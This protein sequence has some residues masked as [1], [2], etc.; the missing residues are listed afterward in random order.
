MASAAQLVLVNVV[1]VLLLCSAVAAT[2]EW[3]SFNPNSDHVRELIKRG[4]FV[5][6]ESSYNLHRYILFLING[7]RAYRMLDRKRITWHV[8]F[9]AAKFEAGRWMVVLVDAML[10]NSETSTPQIHFNEPFEPWDG[11]L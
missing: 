9:T 11:Q 8:V 3:V 2:G 4:L 1:V 6:D 10:F 7:L 5:N